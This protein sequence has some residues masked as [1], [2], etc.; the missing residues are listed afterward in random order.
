MLQ[1][2]GCSNSHGG[3]GN[4]NARSPSCL[5]IFSRIVWNNTNPAL[6]KLNLN[7]KCFITARV[8]MTLGRRNNVQ[9]ARPKCHIALTLCNLSFWSSPE[10]V[11]LQSEIWFPIIVLGLSFHQ[12]SGEMSSVSHFRVV[13]N[14]IAN[15]LKRIS[16]H[17]NILHTDTDTVT[18]SDF[19]LV[20]IWKNYKRPT[21]RRSI[22]SLWQAGGHVISTDW[23]KNRK[24]T[25]TC[26]S[27]WYTCIYSH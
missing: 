16:H 24:H 8:E 23:I 13:L 15:V 5:I 10:D 9:Y 17:H 20:Y 12:R 18:R 2:L 11:I 4:V 27:C 1:D 26:N 21:W 19:K 22:S 14:L 3:A 6:Q 25:Q 7:V